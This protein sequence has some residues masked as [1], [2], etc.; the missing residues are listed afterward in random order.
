MSRRL[1]LLL[2]MLLPLAGQTPIPASGPSAQPQTTPPAPGQS[3]SAPDS[4]SGTAAEATSPVAPTEP[5]LTGW[6]DLGYRWRTDVAAALI[7]T[8]AL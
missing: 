1:A 3:A 2:G 6:V 7:R 8:E 4:K 5:W